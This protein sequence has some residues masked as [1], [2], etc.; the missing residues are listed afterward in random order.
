MLACCIERRDRG[1]IFVVGWRCFRGVWTADV[2]LK[3][4]WKA[5]KVSMVHLLRP[6]GHRGRQR[7]AQTHIVLVVGHCRGDCGDVCSGL[8]WCVRKGQVMACE[9]ACDWWNLCKRLFEACRIRWFVVRYVTGS[10]HGDDRR[11]WKRSRGRYL[12]KAV[13]SKKDPTI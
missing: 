4:N 13:G 8:S 3:R 6:T 2:P 9:W 7:A 11:A 12:V 1:D 10:R 5:V